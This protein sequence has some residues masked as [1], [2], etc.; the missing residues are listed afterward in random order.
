MKIFSLLSFA[1]V[2]VA[3]LATFFF[4][5]VSLY[6]VV[7]CTFLLLIAAGDYGPKVRRSRIYSVASTQTPNARGSSAHRYRL[8]A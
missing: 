4:G 2:L 3:A 7:P 1:A 5:S 6:A 8:A